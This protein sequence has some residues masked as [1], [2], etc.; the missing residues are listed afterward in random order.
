MR[1]VPFRQYL[2]LEKLRR[3]LPGHLRALPYHDLL[4]GRY[5][6]MFNL[7]REDV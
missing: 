6:V 5:E 1:R 4:E 7:D 2:L 3:T